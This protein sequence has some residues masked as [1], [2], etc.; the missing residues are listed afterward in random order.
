MSPIEIVET[1]ITALQS[2]DYEQASSLITDTFTSTGFGGPIP[3]TLD[4]NTFL[5]LQ[6]A[7]FDAIP[8]MD[9]NLS[10][11]E[12]QDHQVLAS[13]NLSGTQTNEL[14]L[15]FPQIS[16]IQAL[17]NTITLP[18]ETVIFTF[19]NNKIDT[20]KIKHIPGGGLEGLLQQLD[21]E[22][23]PTHGTDLDYHPAGD[24]D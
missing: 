21:G 20:M 24:P 5:G 9:Y 11:L 3:Q 6:G 13:I 14:D 1:F 19:K 2:G 10:S 15:P 17:Q 18:A 23:F 22:I 8:D 12:L 4:K 16:P 7:L